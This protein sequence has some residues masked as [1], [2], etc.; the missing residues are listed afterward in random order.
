MNT[1]GLT[2]WSDHPLITLEKSRKLENYSS[3]FPVVELD[4]SFYAIPPQKNISSW[5]E[6]TPD[7][8]QFIPKAYK[9]MTQ[10]KEWVEE[11][12]SIDQMFEVFNQT[13]APMLKENKIKAFLFQFPPYFDCT[14]QNV[15][16][17][18]RVRK[19]MHDL[20]V[21]IEFRSQSWFTEQN[22][23]KTLEFLR[24]LNFIN[25][26]VDQP[27]TPNNS[28]PTIPVSTN[29]SLSIYRLHGRNYGGWLGE[30]IKDWRSERTLYNYDKEELVDFSKTAKSLEKTSHEVCIIFNNNSG[31]H[32]A[33]NA[34]SLQE[35]LGITFNNLSPR[36]L[37]LF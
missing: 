24:Q 14:K 15:T 23:N 27:Q 36:Q 1:I 3:Y 19:L 25:V 26:I 6:K 32:A 22:K 2:G 12:S 5:I 18:R 33:S 16:Y 7:T 11:F 8:F 37:D 20:P 30:D 17:L 9:A 34:L 28:V 13:F 35:I 29:D 21:A 4:T 10:H 31:G